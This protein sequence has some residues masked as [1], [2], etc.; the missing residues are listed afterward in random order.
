MKEALEGVTLVLSMLKSANE[1]NSGR[2][3]D[4]IEKMNL[5]EQ[6]LLELSKRKVREKPVETAKEIVL[7][8]QVEQEPVPQNVLIQ[9]TRGKVSAVNPAEVGIGPKRSSGGK[10]SPAF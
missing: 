10:V 6:V 2:F 3:K 1:N 8:N 4:L 7:P 5:C 9:P